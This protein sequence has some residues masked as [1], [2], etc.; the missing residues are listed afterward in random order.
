MVD[1]AAAIARAI[2]EETKTRT[3]LQALDVRLVAMGKPERPDPQEAK[4]KRKL[5]LKLRLAFK[6]ER[7]EGGI[8]DGSSV[9]MVKI[10]MYVRMD[11]VHKSCRCASTER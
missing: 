11:R 1:S 8:R 9:T 2:P 3:R 7:E 5:K 6:L 10:R 4:P